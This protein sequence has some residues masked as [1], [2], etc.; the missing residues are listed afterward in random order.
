MIWGSGRQAVTEFHWSVA[1]AC[2]Q[3]IGE[4]WSLLR[5][6]E[7]PRAFFCGRQQTY[8]SLQGSNEQRVQSLTGLVAVADILEGFSC[9]LSGN[10]QQNLLTTAAEMGVISIMRCIKLPR[11]IGVGKIFGVV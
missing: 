8:L 7:L 11:L 5:V 4:I 1:S 9:V 10:V 6:S 2:G 3:A